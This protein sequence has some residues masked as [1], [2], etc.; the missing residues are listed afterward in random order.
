MNDTLTSLAKGGASAVT[1]LSPPEGSAAAI[2]E[3]H[4]PQPVEDKKITGGLD[5]LKTLINNHVLSYYHIAPSQEKAS[6]QNLTRVLGNRSPI[7]ADRLSAMLAS[8]R[9]RPPAMRFVV[10]WIV[11]SRLGPD[12]DPATTFLPWQWLSVIQSMGNAGADDKG[13]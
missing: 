6:A 10:A 3:N 5:S 1:N 8:P 9:T 11:L 13:T 12:S 2:V 7:V 4:L